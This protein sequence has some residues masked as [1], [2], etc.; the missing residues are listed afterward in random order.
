[1][2][3]EGSMVGENFFCLQEIIQPYYGGVITRI[4]I[5]L[6]LIVVANT[7]EAAVITVGQNEEW[8]SIQEA[9]DKANPGDIVE[10][11]PGTYYENIKVNKQLILRG[12]GGPVVDA[13]SEY[14]K[15]AAIALYANGTTLE[16]F[17]AVNSTNT[18]GDPY[19]GAGIEVHSNNNTIINNTVRDNYRSGIHLFPSVRD[20][21]ILGNNISHNIEGIYLSDSKNN[22]ILGNNIANN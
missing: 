7:A 11:H 15:G 12:L 4:I 10:V 9:I 19:A 5:V 18:P 3:L 13:G 1:M 20:N 22:T 14:T 16:G 17:T 6:I 8:K 21:D 2:P